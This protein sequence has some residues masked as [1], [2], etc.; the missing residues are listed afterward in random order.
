M[1]SA[2]IKARKQEEERKMKDITYR[3]KLAYI[4]AGCGIMMFALFGMLPGSFLGG[5]MGL[6]I[7]GTLLGSPVTSGV[8]AR[9]IVAGSMVVG[10]MV[11]CIMFVTAASTASWLIGSVVDAIKGEKKELAAVAHK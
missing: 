2:F 9:L 6:N 1:V 11:S 3:K 10:V 8:L 7:A 4:G 5:V